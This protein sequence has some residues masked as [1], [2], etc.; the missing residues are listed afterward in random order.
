MEYASATLPSE[1]ALVRRALVDPAAFADLYD[2]YFPKIWNYVRY[3]VDF[4]PVTDDVTSGVFERALKNYTP[5]TRRRRHFRPGYSPS[6]A[7][8]APIT[9]A[10]AN[11][12][13]GCLSTCLES[14]QTMRRG[15]PK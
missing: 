7:T 9:T 14:A 1:P 12:G 6:P 10:L 3:R 2:H 15:R 4:A 13:A 11:G 5:T 8:A